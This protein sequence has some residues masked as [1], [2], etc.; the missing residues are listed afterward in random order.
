MEA[1]G[2]LR[3]CLEWRVWVHFICCAL[4]LLWLLWNLC[5]ALSTVCWE[6][7]MD[8]YRCKQPHGGSKRTKTLRTGTARRLQSGM[9]EWKNGRMEEVVVPCR[10]SR[11]FVVTANPSRPDAARRRLLGFCLAAWMPERGGGERQ[12]IRRLCAP[13]HHPPVTGP[14]A[15]RRVCIQAPSYLYQNRPS[16]PTAPIRSTFT[17]SPPPPPLPLPTS[18]RTPPPRSSFRR[19]SKSISRL[20]CSHCFPATSDCA[21][22]RNTRLQLHLRTLFLFYIIFVEACHFARPCWRVQISNPRNIPQPT[23][24]CSP[25]M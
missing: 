8:G 25:S 12:Y 11:G 20:F 7:P 18:H 14:T 21:S 9:E 4:S 2:I 24:P 5:S 16:P 22:N 3:E 15:A 23:C 10:L 19:Q 1:A 17:T 13:S 6:F